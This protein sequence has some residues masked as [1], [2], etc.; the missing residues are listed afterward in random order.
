MYVI[1]HNKTDGGNSTESQFS[2][3]TM[4]G[5]STVGVNNGTD[6]GSSPTP[7]AGVSDSTVPTPAV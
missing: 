7:P 6:G 3:V 1:D 5:N 2:N 4:S